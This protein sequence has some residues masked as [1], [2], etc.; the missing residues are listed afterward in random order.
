MAE[1]RVVGKSMFGSL[2]TCLIPTLATPALRLH[3][4]VWRGKIK[5]NFLILLSVEKKCL[6][7]NLELFSSKEINHGAAAGMFFVG[8]VC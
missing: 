6:S 7:C 8:A 3:T 1:H 4:S 5:T 2:I